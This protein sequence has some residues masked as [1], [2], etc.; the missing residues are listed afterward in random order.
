MKRPACGFRRKWASGP[1]RAARTC[2]GPDGVVVRGGRSAANP[3]ARRGA[4]RATSVRC[5]L[6]APLRAAGIPAAVCSRNATDSRVA[7]L[8]RR[9]QLW[10][11]RVHL[12]KRL[13]VQGAPPNSPYTSAPICQVSA[14]VLVTG[15]SCAATGST[16]H[17]AR[18][19]LHLLASNAYRREALEQLRAMSVM[20]A[21]EHAA[22][23][24]RWERDCCCARR[25][26]PRRRSELA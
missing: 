8:N 17:R 24:A 14:H 25:C 26:W 13:G 1:R 3:S 11:G 18:R 9:W 6:R 22:L 20:R 4:R 19:F 7:A 21:H 2:P 16:Q 10:A 5:C 12:R 23:R 15:A